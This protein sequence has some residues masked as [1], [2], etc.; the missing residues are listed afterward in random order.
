MKGHP[1]LVSVCMI[2]FNHEPYIHVAIESVLMQKCQFRFELVIG[3]D[4]STDKSRM[5]CEKYAE[6]YPETI[7]LLPSEKNLGVIP[8]FIRTLQACTGGY[9]ALCEGDDYWTDPFKLQKQVDFLDAN[10]E[11]GL[12][13]TDLDI[14]FQNSSILKRNYHL[15]NSTVCQGYLFESLLI[16]NSIATLTVMFRSDFLKVIDFNKMNNFKM[17]DIFIW[18]EIA[19]HFKIGFVNDSTAVYRVHNDSASSHFGGRRRSDFIFSAYNLN[20][21]FIEKYGCTVETKEK[22]YRKALNAWFSMNERNYFNDSY[23]HLRNIYKLKFEE[24]VQYWFINV[25]FMWYL[26]RIFGKSRNLFINSLNGFKEK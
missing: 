5:I 12:V 22:V 1:T 19:R 21:Y 9:I 8:N 18:L 15:C 4:C 7:K 2:T 16:D 3:E 25:P 24:K 6:I 13:H 20:Y 14:F 26:Y 23:N 17:G 11:Y 10:P